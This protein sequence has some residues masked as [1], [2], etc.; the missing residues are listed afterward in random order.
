MSLMAG[1]AFAFAAPRAE[2]LALS[3][4]PVTGFQ[5]GVSCISTTLCVVTGYD[6]GGVGDVVD[7]HKGVPGP[8]SVI[9]GTKAVYTVSCPAGAGCVALGVTSNDVSPVLV[10]IGPSGAVESSKTLSVPPGVSLVRISCVSLTTCE[11]SGTDIFT[12]PVMLEMGRWDGAKLTLQHVPLPHG[13]SAPALEALSCSGSQC[14]AV[15]SA[16]SG[17]NSE[18]LVLRTTGGTPVL[19]TVADASIYGV[20][21]TS[22]SLC[23]GAGF[24]RTGGL[25]MTIKSGVASSTVTLTQGDMMAIACRASSCTAVGEKLAPPGAPAKDV[26]YGVLV[27]LSDGKVTSSEMVPASGGFTNVAQ[28]GGAYAAVGAAQGK[29]TEVTTFA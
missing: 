3:S 17:S 11:L 25:A 26:Y 8:V 2:A 7:I 28:Y 19:H 15:G 13:A 21:C 9:A 6:D 24:T 4:H 1:A 20:A 14:V 23:Y 12:S 5:F 18:G 27:G 10:T 22:S 16:F 29:G